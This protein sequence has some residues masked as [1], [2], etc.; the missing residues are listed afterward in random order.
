MADG[1]TGPDFGAMLALN[2]FSQQSNGSGRPVIIAAILPGGGADVNVGQQLSSQNGGLKFDA[3]FKAT[4]QARPGM[5]RKLLA[6]MGVSGSGIM[7]G[8]KKVGDAGAP[9]QINSITEIQGQAST[10]GSSGSFV[11]NLGPRGG[12]MEI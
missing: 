10:G 11:D 9:R 6:D 8:M 5:F 3:T 4:A 7:D 1:P 2:R 12:S